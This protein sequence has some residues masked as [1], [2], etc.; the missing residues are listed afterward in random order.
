MIH[1]GIMKKLFLLFTLSL[2]L[3][4]M[5]W[6]ASAVVTQRPSHIDLSTATSESAVLMTL[7]G[8]TSNDA[9]YRLYNGG[10]N[11]DCW[12]EV[13]DAYISSNS[14]AAGPQVPGTPITS[15]TFWILSQRGNNNTHVA[16][17]RDRQGPGYGSNYQTAA[18]P[19]ATSITAPFTLSGTFS[20][21]NDVKHVVLGFDGATLVTAASTELSTG[22]FTL[23]APTGTTISKIEIRQVDNTSLGNLTGTWSAAASG[24]TISAGNITAAPTFDPPAGIY[25]TTLNVSISS[26]TLGATIR[27]TTNG[28][29]PS[30]TVGTIYNTPIVVSANTTIKAIAYAVGYDPSF[31]STAVYEYPTAVSNIA[32]LRAG[33]AGGTVYKLTG[34]AVLTYKNAARNV[35]Y[36]QDATAAIVIDDA[37]GKISTNYDLYDGITG[38][39]GTLNVYNG[40][41]QFIPVGDPGAATSINNVV[42]PEIRTLSSLTSADQGKLIKVQGTA[43]T[44]ATY[45]DFPAT[46]QNLNAADATGTVILRTFANTDYANTPIPVVAVDLISLVGQFGT[47]MQV[48]P[49]FLSDIQYTGGGTPTIILSGTIDPM[50]NIAGLPSEEFGQYNL[51]GIDL[52]QNISV[53]APEHFEV[54]SDFEGPFSSTLSLS[55]AFDGT[56]YVRIISEIVGEHSGDIVHSSFGAANAS[57]R[58]TGETIAPDG[59]ITVNSTMTAFYQEIGTPSASQSYSFTST[60]LSLSTEIAV[61]APFELSQNGSS[62]WA[63]SINVASNYNGLIY[64]RLNGTEFGE[65][66]DIE[67]THTNANASP[68][69]ITVSGT[70][71]VVAGPVENLFFSEYIEGSSNNKAIEIFNASG[72][73]VDLS[74]YKVELYSNGSLTVGNTL[75][76]TGI[77]AAGDVYVIANAQAAPEILAVA[78]VTSTVTFFNGDDALALRCIN[79]DTIIDVFGEIGVDP[80]TGW[81]VAGLTNATVDHTLIRKPTVVSGN[82]D[83]AAQFGTDVNNS[84]WIVQDIDYFDNIGIHNFGSGPQYTAAPVF[85]PVG[86]TFTETTNVS[87]TC[88]TENSVIRYTLDGSVPTTEI[89]TIYVSAIPITETTTIKAIAY[90]TGFE[91]SAVVTHEYTITIQ[92]DSPFVHYWNF[93]A[94]VPATNANWDQP[95]NATQGTG[96]LTYSFANAVS[97]GGTAINGM[98][99]EVTG[100]S[101]VPQGGE[102]NINNGEHLDL[103]APTTGYENII[104]S[105]ATR[106]TSTGFSSQEIQYSINGIDF[107][108]KETV[109]VSAHANNWVA[110]QVITV[111]FS[112]IPAA[113]NNPNFKIRVVVT[114]ATT[115]TGNNRFDNIQVNGTATS[116]GTLDTPIVTI[117]QNGTNVDLSWTAIPGA[118]SYRIE[119]SDDPYGTFTQVGSTTGNTT[120]SIPATPAKKFYRVIALP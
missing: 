61:P 63:Q 6:G 51:S 96:Q 114:G 28:T 112:E 45:T 80:G 78:D 76:L 77:L 58:A 55:P 67:I 100:G 11:Y 37:S 8:Y 73:A 68:V 46:A 19:A 35:K 22:T 113:N 18:L 94:D 47:D 120:I 69:S 98:D 116:G 34:E 85:D 95:I 62:A 13:G 15:S 93:N 26:E 66:T 54:A 102:E 49:R 75:T 7:S 101:F 56:I 97:Y 10:N 81:A 108:N 24:I 1:G 43:I 4:S 92:G 9:R 72:S 87:L 74:R 71:N 14:Y 88:S 79:P 115:S 21:S 99:A 5:A 84:E 118:S 44:H 53:A 38:I 27:Y 117:V 103:A 82:I 119:S 65:Y 91:P 31:V 30:S 107:I 16:S 64:V 42:T 109:D 105:Y 106:R 3:V 17:Y 60:G 2:L 110:G 48:S 70:V 25:S 59:E 83:W 36:I 52:T 50:I 23:T 86:G 41:L 40:L 33:T 12:D 90:A 29:E 20:G 57:I 32:A 111:D 89:G 104:L 39:T